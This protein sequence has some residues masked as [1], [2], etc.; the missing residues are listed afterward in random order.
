M[1]TAGIVSFNSRTSPVI[2]PLAAF[3][4]TEFIAVAGPCQH[5]FAEKVPPMI[6]SQIVDTLVIGF[7]QSQMC[8][9][10]QIVTRQTAFGAF[11]AAS[12]LIH[13]KLFHPTPTP[14][15]KRFYRFYP[16]LCIVSP[17]PFILPFVS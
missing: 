10:V 5:T 2:S 16:E 3:A 17:N 13:R 8:P 12:K 11:C 14:Y 6:G 7:I 15:P 9:V 1:K 4:A